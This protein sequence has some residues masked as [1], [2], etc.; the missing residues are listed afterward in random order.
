[1]SEPATDVEA[2]YP[3]V[4][5]CLPDEDEA[6]CIGCGRPWGAPVVQMPGDDKAPGVAPPP[7]VAPA[8]P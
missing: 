1:M 2:L 3:C 8:R 5:I 6:Y 7:P 4:G